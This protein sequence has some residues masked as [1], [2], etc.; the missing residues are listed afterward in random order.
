MDELDKR[1]KAT[2]WYTLDHVTGP[3]ALYLAISFGLTPPGGPRVERRLRT[4]TTDA[5]YKFEVERCVTEILAGVAEAN[6][7]CGGAIAVEAIQ[8]YPDDYPSPWQAKY[9][10]YRI[11]RRALEDQ[12]FSFPVVDDPRS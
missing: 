7:R 3:S 2:T 9:V 1:I 10:A 6:E 8:F 11:A 4:S 5:T 12:G